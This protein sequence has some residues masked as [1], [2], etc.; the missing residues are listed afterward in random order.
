ME[1]LAYENDPRIEFQLGHVFSDMEIGVRVSHVVAALLA[2]QLGHVFSDMEI[3]LRL[4]RLVEKVAVLVFQLGHVFSDMEIW[5]GM[6]EQQ[7][8]DPN[9]SIGPRL[10]RHGN[11]RGH[12]KHC[13][14]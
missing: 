5:R 1:F 8:I 9:V 7:E 4:Q 6:Y 12:A 13:N 10:F 2:F 11:V 3:R 14:C